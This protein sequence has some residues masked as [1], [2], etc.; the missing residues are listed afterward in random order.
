MSYSELYVMVMTDVGSNLR[1]FLHHY[2]IVS[3]RSIDC[4]IHDHFHQDET[5]YNRPG[6]VAAHCGKLTEAEMIY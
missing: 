4:S 3:Q 5:S 2:D 6:T 1:V